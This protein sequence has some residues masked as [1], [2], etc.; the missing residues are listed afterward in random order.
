MMDMMQKMK[1]MDMGKMK[2]MDTTKAKD[3]TLHH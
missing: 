2:G 1:G 3:H